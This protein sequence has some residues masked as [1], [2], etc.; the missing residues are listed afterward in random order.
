MKSLKLKNILCPVDLSSASG[1]IL[2]WAGLFAR[3]FEAMLEILHGDWWEPPRYFSE[4]QIQRLSRQELEGE[5]VLR[6]DLEALA[7]AALGSLHAGNIAVV[8]GHPSEQILQRAKELKAGLI[9]M[10]S[11]GRT[12][13][14]RLRL[15][16]IAEDVVRESR[17]PVLIVKTAKETALEPS[18]QNILCPINFTNLSQ[19]SL[20]I[21]SELA[22]A[23]GARLC[24]VHATDHD[25]VNVEEVHKRI[26]DWVPQEVRG[27]CEVSEVVRQGNPAEQILLMVRERSDDLIVMGAQH[28]PLLEF[29]TLGTTTERVMRHSLASVMVIPAAKAVSGM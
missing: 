4:A 18:I 5:K 20:E 23:F 1:D 6:R 24:V 27:R 2:R 17:C 10:G 19:Q 13:I 22:S 21:S 14:A 26:C 28:R 16:S 11:H 9:V 7:K 25:E 29:T 12:G 15:G 3:T 8:E